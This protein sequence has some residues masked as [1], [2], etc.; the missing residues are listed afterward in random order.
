M[1]ATAFVVAALTA[2]LSGCSG[3]ELTASRAAEAIRESDRLTSGC[4]VPGGN[5]TLTGAGVSE[6]LFVR[7]SGSVPLRSPVDLTERGKQYFEAIREPTEFGALPVLLPRE[8]PTAIIEVTGI[9]DGPGDG[10]RQ[11]DFE[12]AYGGLSD[13]VARYCHAGPY[14]K[15]ALLRLVDGGWRVEEIH[16]RR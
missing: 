6:A 14:K 15:R 10:V 2:V 7:K 3:G 13:V 8:K 1:R 16:F 4:F 5:A 12:H 11:V 9:A